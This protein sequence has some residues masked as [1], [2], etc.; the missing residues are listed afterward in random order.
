MF[1]TQHEIQFRSYLI[2]EREGRPQGRDWDHWFR[3]EA[4]LAREQASTAKSAVSKP[5]AARAPRSPKTRAAKKPAV[6][7]D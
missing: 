3:A 2:W 5:V 1:A 4:E 6:K 7:K